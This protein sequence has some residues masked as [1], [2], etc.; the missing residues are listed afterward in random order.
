MKRLRLITFDLDDTLWDVWP[1]IRQ[2]EAAQAAW[3]DHVR[4]DWRHPE[5][6]NLLQLRTRVLSEQPQLA[7]DLSALRRAVLTQRFLE[8]GE[9]FAQAQQIAHEAF[10]V[11]HAARQRV[12]IFPGV[13]DTLAALAQQFTLIAV[14][15]GNACVQ[16]VGLG[17]VFRDQFDP[18]RVGVAKPDPLIFTAALRAAEVEPEEA[19]HVGDHPEQD[20]RAAQ[21]IGM[22]GVWVNR[23]GATWTHDQAADGTLTCVT[24]LPHWLAQQGIA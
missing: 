4:S 1:V 17:D 5:D 8:L 19:L 14:T 18:A 7:H 11:F 10:E 9:P 16:R 2:A 23:T 12:T 22:R 6:D 15:N 20:V 24:E 3:L 13:A 21:A